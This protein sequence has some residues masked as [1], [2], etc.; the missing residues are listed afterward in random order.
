MV[1]RTVPLLGAYAWKEVAFVTESP[2]ALQRGD[3]SGGLNQ[4]IDEAFVRAGCLG[5]SVNY[6]LS[7]EVQHPEHVKDVAAAVTWL[8]RNI[9][10]FGGDPDK[11]LLVGHSAGAHLVMQ[12]LA[13]PQYLKAAGMEQPVDTFVK[14]AVGISGVYNI[15]RL[16][17]TSFYGTLVTNPP[18]GERVEQWRVAS[19]GM[20]VTRVGSSSPLTKMPLLLVNAQEDFHFQEDAQELERW[21][22]AAGNTRIQRHVVPNCNHFTIVQHLAHDEPDTNE[23]MRLIKEFVFEVAD[24]DEVAPLL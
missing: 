18:F 3:K 19:I 15:V 13:D 17:N 24:P 8:H 4:D 10:K 16:A 5:V 7:P 11:L 9:A 1:R 12:I 6:R 14:G 23:T 20:T 22:H 2:H 21:L